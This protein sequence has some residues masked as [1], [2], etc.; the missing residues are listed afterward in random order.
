MKNSNALKGIL[1]LLGI[2]LIVLGSWRLFDPIGFFV[3]SG[4]ILGNDTG[5]MNEARATGGV[6]V[7]FGLLIITG[8]FNQKISYTSTIASVILFFGFGIGRLIGFIIDGYPNELLI[9]GVIFE[10]IFGSLGLFALLKY[11]ER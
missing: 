11:K 2:V 8:S 6:I 4:L 10:F 1:I 7:A 9:Q 3:N 5:L